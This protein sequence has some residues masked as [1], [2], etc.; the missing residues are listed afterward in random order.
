M[1]CNSPRGFNSLILRVCL[2]GITP[3]SARLVHMEHEV[4]WREVCDAQGFAHDFLDEA[5]DDLDDP[6]GEFNAAWESA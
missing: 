4:I 6:V 5:N 2:G 3:P 1:G